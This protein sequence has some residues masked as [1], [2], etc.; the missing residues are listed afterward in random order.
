MKALSAL[1]ALALAAAAVAAP[2]AAH[3]QATMYDGML[4]QA[5]RQSQNLTN[6]MNSQLGGMLQQAMQN[7]QIQAGYQ[8]YVAQMQ[9]RGQPPMDFQTYAYYYMYTN[10]FSS[11]G[12]AHMQNVERGNQQAEM[13]S[14]RGLQDAQR[15]RADAMQQNRDHYFQNQQEAGRGLTGQSTYYGQGGFQTQLPH[16]WQNNSYQ[17]YQGN[18]YYVDQGG[19]YFRIENG[20]MVPINR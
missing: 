4:Q 14:W 19:R 8:Q 3:A 20:W 2:T 9:Q 11:G 7:P 5:L 15:N 10:G 16:T 6:Q 17:Q 18:W 12:I 13:Q 1:H